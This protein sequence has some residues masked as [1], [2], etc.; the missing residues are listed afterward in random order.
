MVVP[1]VL[2]VTAAGCCG[3]ALL[4][5]AVMKNASTEQDRYM[6]TGQQEIGRISR[7]QYNRSSCKT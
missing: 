7:R 3:K 1:L 4:L 6:Y 2:A 5:L